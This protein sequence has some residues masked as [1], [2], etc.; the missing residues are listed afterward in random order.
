M[1]IQQTDK[2]LL[3]SIETRLGNVEKTLEEIMENGEMM[4]ERLKEKL[5]DIQDEIEKNTLQVKKMRTKLANTLRP[6]TIMMIMALFIF[7]WIAFVH[8]FTTS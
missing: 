4:E 6:R 1:Q 7:L 3:T 5:V 8:L 2:V